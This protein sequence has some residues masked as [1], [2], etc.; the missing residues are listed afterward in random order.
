MASRALR[1]DPKESAG[2]NRL[3]PQ[4]G[5]YRRPLVKTPSPHSHTS[6]GRS[7]AVPS[8]Q[9]NRIGFKRNKN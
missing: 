4:N 7:E 1:I 5:I 8:D 2:A 6:Y 9:T 3:I